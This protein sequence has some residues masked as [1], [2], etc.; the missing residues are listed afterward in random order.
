MTHFKVSDEVVETAVRAINTSKYCLTDREKAQIAIEAALP[1]M[2]EKCGVYTRSNH[3]H[4]TKQLHDIF[5]AI[6]NDVTVYRP[7]ESK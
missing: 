4:C 6:G 5:T 3:I 2:F 7:K 1:V